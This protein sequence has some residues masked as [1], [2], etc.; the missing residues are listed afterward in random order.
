MIVVKLN[1]GLGNQLF[2]YAAGRSISMLTNQELYLDTT[3][4]DYYPMHVNNTKRRYELNHFCITAPK[5]KVEQEWKRTILRNKWLFAAYTKWFLG[6]NRLTVI[7]ENNYFV[8]KNKN[9]SLYLDDYFQSEEYFKNIA[10]IIKADFLFKKKPNEVNND[11][12]NRI[13]GCQSISIHVRRGD[14]LNSTNA[15]IYHVC[16]IEYYEKAIKH[17]LESVVNPV[18][19]VFSDDIDWVKENLSI[20]HP[21]IYVEHNSGE[22]AYEDLRLMISCKHNIIS[23]STFAWWAAWLNDNKGKIVVAPNKWFKEI[24]DDS[25]IPNNWVKI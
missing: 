4:L 9:K 5:L 2:Q 15:S 16:T 17:I 1:G 24:I 12:I 7:N 13:S 23:N 22:L 3:F 18:F 21:T 11:M 25:I 6:W 20:K 10:K 14:Y 8:E 19:Y